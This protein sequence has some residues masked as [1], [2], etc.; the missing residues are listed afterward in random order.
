MEGLI[1][2]DVADLIAW[3]AVKHPS[4]HHRQFV[5]AGSMSGLVGTASNVGCS[6]WR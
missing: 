5:R 6:A 3:P 4:R 1:V 2:I